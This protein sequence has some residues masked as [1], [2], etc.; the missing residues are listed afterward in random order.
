[1]SHYMNLTELYFDTS[2]NLK[3]FSIVNHSS[4]TDGLCTSRPLQMRGAVC[5]IMEVTGFPTD[6]ELELR[7]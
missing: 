1:M 6:K 2:D 3:D 4:H 7:E 5:L